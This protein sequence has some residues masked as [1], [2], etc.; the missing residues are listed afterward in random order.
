MKKRMYLVAVMGIC[1]LGLVSCG[2]KSKVETFGEYTEQELFADIPAMTAEG[3]TIGEAVD[4]GNKDYIITVEGTKESDYT[5][6]VSLLEQ[7]GFEKYAENSLDNAVFNTTLTKDKK[8]VVVIH[9]KN[10]SRTYI[11]VCEGRELSA[12]LKYDDSYTEG[13]VEGA[14]TKMHM[15]ELYYFGGSYIIQ[16]KNGHF[17]VTDGGTDYDTPYLIDYLESLTPDGGKP[18][19]EA[20]IISHPHYDHMGV[21]RNIGDYVDRILV[22]GV[23]YC[24]LSKTTMAMETGV[25]T[26]NTYVKAAANA[27][28]TTDGKS[29]KIYRMQTGQRYYFNDITMD[30]LFTQEQLLAADYDDGINETSTWC[31]F[32]I[33][34]E[35]ILNGADAG[36]GGMKAIMSMYSQE[37]LTIDMFVALHHGHNSRSDFGEY[38]TIKDAVLYSERSLPGGSA[39]VK[40]VESTPEY[41]VY[42]DGTKIFTF[43]YESGTTESLENNTWKYNAGETRPSL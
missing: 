17:V 43:P 14:K 35:T 2:T 11:S 34:G 9:L 39:N 15:V 7:E 26:E 40:M 16:L 1:L 22:E 23:Y 3:T 28:R 4:Y 42:G 19:I 38:I 37:Y 5:E 41:F 13:N 18:I 27:L 10:L 30:V 33:D 31:M 12:H 6:Y 29:S 25:S 8:T 20:W 24:E 21:L 32:T 36:A